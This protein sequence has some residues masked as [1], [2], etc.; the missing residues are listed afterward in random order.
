MENR[1]NVLFPLGRAALGVLFFVSGLLKIGGFAG[2]AGYM[3]SQGLPIANILLVGVIVL[4]VGGGL[5]LITGW[6]ARW[7]ALALALFLIPTTLIFHAFWS[8]DAAHF[9]DQLTNFLK[10]LSIFGGMLLLVERGFRQAK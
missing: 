5:L 4:E 2:V 1:S 9:Q 6:Q 8:A 7:A 3:A 10:N